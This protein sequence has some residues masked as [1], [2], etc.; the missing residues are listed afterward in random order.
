MSGELEITAGDQ[1]TFQQSIKFNN[2]RRFAESQEEF[3]SKYLE[4]FP[5]KKIA[6]VI[7]A[8]PESVPSDVNNYTVVLPPCTR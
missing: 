5:G 2:F 3:K 8:L 4:V 1:Q 7:K 6:F